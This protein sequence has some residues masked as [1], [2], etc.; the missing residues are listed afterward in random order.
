MLPISRRHFLRRLGIAT[1]A[2]ASL[3]LVHRTRA[4]DAPQQKRHVLILGAGLAGLCAAYELERK[5]HTVTILEAER[6]HVGGRVRTLRFENG[7]YGEAGAMRVPA[8]HAITRHYL[9]ELKLPLRKFV[10]SNPEAYY[11]LRGRR[12]R[13]KDVRSLYE[14]YKLTPDEA[15][16]HP[17]DW[18]AKAVTGHVT[19]MSADEKDQLTGKA[20]FAEKLRGLDRKS[21]GDL[22]TDTGLSPDAAELLALTAGQEMELSTGATETLREELLDFWSKGFDEIVGGTDTFATAFAGQL[23]SKP[24][25]GCEVRT[26]W[27]DGTRKKAGVLYRENGAE[28][29][30]EADL[31]ICTIPLPVLSR[32]QLDPAFSAAKMRAIRQLN[33]D[34]AT[35][36]LAVCDRRFWE[37]DDQIFGGGSYTDLPIGTAYYPSDNAEKRDPAVSAGPGVMLASYSWGQGARRLGSLEPTVAHDVTRRHLA[38]VHPQLADPKTARHWASWSWDTHANTGGAFA[39]FLPGQHDALHAA[40]TAPE[41]RITL[42]GE[43]ASLAHTWMQGALESALRAV[44]W[45]TR[46]DI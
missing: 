21:L 38:R 39:W 40:L 5:G 18:W 1:G 25:L 44:E 27:Q 29:T 23:Q 7:L 3:S 36:V 11:F 30:A 9:A 32:L 6:A 2:V 20:P 4:A 19:G 28:K 10:Q 17:D 15:K 8:V 45:V 24:R 13:I 35:K 16:Q 34:A 22:I 33:Y 42:A 26:V 12:A 14:L 43:H 41:G 37:A 46:A 31:I